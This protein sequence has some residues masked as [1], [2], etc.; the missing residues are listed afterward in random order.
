MKKIHIGQYRS[1]ETGDIFYILEDVE[2]GTT[3]VSDELYETLIEHQQ[4]FFSMQTLLN[5]IIDDSPEAAAD[6]CE[7]FMT[8]REAAGGTKPR[9]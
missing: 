9:H 8:L 7:Q 4:V 6:V 2:Y 3:E 1:P 5:D